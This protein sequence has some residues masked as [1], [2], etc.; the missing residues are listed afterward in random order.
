MATEDSRT[1]AAILASLSIVVPAYNEAERIEASLRALLAWRDQ[2]AAT[3]EIIVVDDGSRDDTV[4]VAQA[5]LRG[6]SQVQ[7][8]ALGRNRGKGAAVRRGVELAT[9]QWILFTD[10]DLSTPM[11]ELAKLL[12]AVQAGADIAIASRDTTGSAIDR[13]Q[14][15]YREAMGRTFNALVRA[16]A[17]GGIA[18]T[19]CGFK[20]FAAVAAR[21]CFSRMTIERFAFDVEVL[22]IARQLGYPICEVGVRWI[23]DERSTVHPIKDAAVMLADVVRIRW[24]HRG[25]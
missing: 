10:A 5:V 21:R 8:A 18:D 3:A 23:N 19:Q 13:H 22:Y 4:A 11:S 1:P 25:N 24:R 12:A 14:P 15:A 9:R 6:H 2:N 17:V 20:L 16:L 7:V